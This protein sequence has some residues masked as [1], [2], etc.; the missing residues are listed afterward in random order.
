MPRRIDHDH[1]VA[2]PSPAP[3]AADEASDSSS[4]EDVTLLSVKPPA[5]KA[6][7]QHGVKNK[8]AKKTKTT[9]SDSR[10]RTAAARDALKKPGT[11]PPI[12]AYLNLPV[13]RP[14]KKTASS[15]DSTTV[16]ES[17]VAE[18][19]DAKP[20]SLLPQKKTRTP[21]GSYQSFEGGEFQ[22]AKRHWKSMGLRSKFIK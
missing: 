9:V 11:T 17:T 22:A 3:S 21:C 20:A 19:S 14:P 5:K 15:N 10:P 16:A 4:E 18:S 13:G 12:F 2:E 8:S 7:L 1:P 6:K